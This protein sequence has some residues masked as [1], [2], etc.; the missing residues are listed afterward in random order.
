MMTE[1]TWEEILQEAQPMVVKQIKNNSPSLPK[2]RFADYDDIPEP[3]G[4]D[5]S[6]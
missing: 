3:T 6:E 5:I 4:E 1:K 2:I